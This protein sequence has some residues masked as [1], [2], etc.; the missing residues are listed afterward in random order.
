MQKQCRQMTDEN[1]VFTEEGTDVLPVDAATQRLIQSVLDENEQAAASELKAVDE[2]C[3][4]LCR[5][6]EQLS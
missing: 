4:E 5:Q 1:I 6:I 3:E 2:Q